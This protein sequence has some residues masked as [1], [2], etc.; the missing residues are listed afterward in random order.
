M[1]EEKVKIAADLMPILSL[2]YDGGI[3][4]VDGGMKG[5]QCT[6]EFFR[7]TFPVYE[8][9]PRKNS[10]YAPYELNYRYNGVLFFALSQT[11]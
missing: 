11:E 2:L 9:Y 3:I 4:T 10:D 5:V 7:E 8:V 1:N 6:E